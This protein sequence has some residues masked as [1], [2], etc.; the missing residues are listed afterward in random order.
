M[1]PLG[2]VDEDELSLEIAGAD[3]AS[4]LLDLPPALPPL[5]RRILLARLIMSLPRY[6]RGPE[7]DF[8]LAGALGRLMDQV[9]TEGLD[10]TRLPDL[11]SGRELAQHWQI[12]VK[13]L[14]ILSR[15]WPEIL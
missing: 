13:F 10:L 9:Y 2:D 14:E 6:T 15:E 4:T 8:A 11:V 1:Q 7:L 5:R 3:S 12:T